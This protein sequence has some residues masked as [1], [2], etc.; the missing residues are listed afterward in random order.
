MRSF[1]IFSGTAEN[2]YTCPDVNSISRTFCA[3]SYPADRRITDFTDCRSMDIAT[4]FHVLWGV[5]GCDCTGLLVGWW[6][7]QQHGCR[8]CSLLQHGII[9][10]LP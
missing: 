4:F 2:R 10:C 7:R 9:R 6:W 1:Q 5:K 3:S 8:E